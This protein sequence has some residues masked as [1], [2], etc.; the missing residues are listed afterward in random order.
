MKSDME[1][2]NA[3]TAH[4]QVNKDWT[5]STK[6]EHAWLLFKGKLST[7]TLALF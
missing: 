4:H 2:N 7:I 5:I 6:K 3:N 1:E